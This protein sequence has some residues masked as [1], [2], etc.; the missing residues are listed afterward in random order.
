[1]WW[2][3][4]TPSGEN[5]DAAYRV[6]KVSFGYKRSQSLV[7]WIQH[8][9]RLIKGLKENLENE[10]AGS[11]EWSPCYTANSLAPSPGQAI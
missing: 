9:I 3:C 8:C 11:H 1:M 10:A 4:L 7:I 2:P 5:I 6:S